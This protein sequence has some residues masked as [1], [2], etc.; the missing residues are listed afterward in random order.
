MNPQRNKI[1]EFVTFGLF[2]VFQIVEA[3]AKKP[4]ALL[5]EYA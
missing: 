3:L 1:F 2:E 4:I 5:D